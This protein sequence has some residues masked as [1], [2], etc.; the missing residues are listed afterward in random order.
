MFGV[1]KQ[2]ERMKFDILAQLFRQSQNVVS[3]WNI[4][5]INS[6]YRR[7]VASVWTMR[8]AFMTGCFSAPLSLQAVVSQPA[9]SDAEVIN[10]TFATY[11]S[12]KAPC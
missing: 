4:W 7:A 9:L 2:E 6:W 3:E 10:E 11:Y 8:G 12:N 1:K 5:M